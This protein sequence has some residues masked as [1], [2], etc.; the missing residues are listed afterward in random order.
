MKGAGVSLPGRHAAH[1]MSGGES[2]GGDTL[3]WARESLGVTVAEIYGQTEANYLVGDSPRRVGGAARLDG[4]A[5]SGPRRRRD[6]RGRRR[7]AGRRDRRDRRTR[8]RPVAFLEYLNAPEATAAKF[9]GPWLRTGDLASRDADGYL[10]FRGRS[11]D[12]IISA[13]YRISPV[14][15]EQCLL[16]HPAVVAAAVVGA[17]DELRGQ[18]VKAFVIARDQSGSPAL[19]EEL[20]QFVR[21]RLA[22]Y[23][24]ARARVRPRAAADGDREDPRRSL[25]RRVTRRVTS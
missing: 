7:A 14:E 5:V 21:T 25:R 2:L 1:V 17:P 8:A 6:R 13:G 10:W 12:V 11:D 22:A 20:K 24:T 19:A 3:A 23:G 4:P 9:V 16:R 15:V 18:I